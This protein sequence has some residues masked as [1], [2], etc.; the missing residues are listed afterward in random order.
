M[1]TR[2]QVKDPPPWVAYD[3]WAYGLSHPEPWV[4]TFALLQ[5]VLMIT[6]LAGL[7]LAASSPL[8]TLAI[9]TLVALSLTGI[10]GFLVSRFRER[11]MYLLIVYS[12]VFWADPRALWK[13]AGD[14]R[15]LVPLVVCIGLFL[16]VSRS[17]WEQLGGWN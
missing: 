11:F 9:G 12:A 15:R 4:L 13:N 8:R 2:I 1:L 5:A 3:E 16:A 14:P 17:T 10:L 6:G 7:I